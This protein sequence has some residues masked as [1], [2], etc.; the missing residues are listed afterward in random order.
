[1]ETKQIKYSYVLVGKQGIASDEFA[2]VRDVARFLVEKYG[3][4]TYWI[5]AY[6][7]VGECKPVKY[8]FFDDVAGFWRS[9]RSGHDY[10]IVNTYNSKIITCDE[11]RE[12][13]NSLIQ[14]R[15]S[16]YRE[17]VRGVPVEGTGKWRSRSGKNASRIGVLRAAQKVD[18]QEPR[19]RVK[20]HNRFRGWGF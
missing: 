5:G 12:E 16:E 8:R 19:V 7:R 14:A 4:H 20:F 10:C 9:D 6:G 15:N 11:L 2:T 1:M 13:V 17:P 18:D 3:W